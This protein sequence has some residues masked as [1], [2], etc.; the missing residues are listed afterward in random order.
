MADE[1]DSVQPTIQ[2]HFLRAADA[3]DSAA[4]AFND[5]DSTNANSYLGQ[6]L[7]EV[8]QGVNAVSESMYC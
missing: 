7:N 8:K 2:Q 6:G 4:S 1:F 3:L 5:V